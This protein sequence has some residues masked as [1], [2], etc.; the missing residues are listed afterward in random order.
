VALFVNEDCKATGFTLDD[1]ER[2]GGKVDCDYR[3]PGVRIADV[4]SGA[5]DALFD[6][7]VTVWANRA[8][9]SGMTFPAAEAFWREQGYL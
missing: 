5:Y 6:E 2:W 4:E 9:G 8:T 1:I 3:L 7:A